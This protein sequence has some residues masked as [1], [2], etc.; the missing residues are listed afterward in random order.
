MHII[1]IRRANLGSAVPFGRFKLESPQSDFMKVRKVG[2][3]I[4]LGL[5]ASL[6][7]KAEPALANVSVTAASGGN[8]IPADRAANAPAPVWTSLGAI[9]IAESSIGKG[10]I[11]S[12]TLILNAPAGF[13]FNP[14]LLPNV[15]FTAGRNIISA[16][17]TVN[18]SNITVTLVVL[19]SDL[20]DTLTIGGSPAIQIR[21]IDGTTLASGNIYRPT[22]GGGT[23]V[24]VGIVSTDSTNGAGGT[25]LGNI[26]EVPGAARQLTAQTLPANSAL[27]GANFSPQPVIQ[28]RDQFGNLR[29]SANG[30]ADNSTV[31]TASLASGTSSLQGTTNVT[32]SNGAATFNNLSY[33]KAE[34]ISVRFSSGSLTGLVTGTI[35]ISPAAASR[36]VFTTQPGSTTYGLPLGTQPVV[37]SQDAYGNS[38]VSGLGVSKPLSLSLSN[39]TGVLQGTTS[40][41]IG[42]GAGNGLATFTNL[43]VTAAGVNLRLTATASGLTNALS[44]PFNVQPVTVTASVTVSN[45][46]YDGTTTAT[47]A[48]RALSGVL[49]VDEVSLNGGVALFANKNAGAGKTVTVTNLSLTGVATN[50][51]QLAATSVST[52]A[53]ISK[54]PLTVT[55]DNKTRVVGQA[56]PPLTASYFGFVN[57]ETLATSGVTGSPALSTAATVG[58]PVGSYAI[59]ATNGSL[60]AVNYSFATLN[61]VLSVIPSGTLFFDDFARTNEPGDLSPWIAQMGTW[62]VTGGVLKSGS[63]VFQSYSYAIITNSW[64]NYSVEGV[65]KFPAGAYGGGFGGQLNPATGAQYLAWVYPE[66]S[67]GGSSILKLIKFNTWTSFGYTNTESIPIQQATLP[68]VGTNWHALRLTFAGNQISVAYDGSEVMSVADL[69]AQPYL[70]GGISVGMWTQSGAD[71][72][73]VDNVFV[74]EAAIIPIANNDSYSVVSGKVLTVSAPGILTNDS[75]LN[76]SA[77]LVTGTTKGSLNLSP[78]GSFAYTPS[79]QFIGTDSFTY[80]ASDSQTNSA[81]ATV[82]INVTTNTPPVAGNDNYVTA[83]DAI[84]TIPPPGVLANDSDANSDALTAVLVNGPAHGSSNL[85]SNGGFV[86]TPTMGFTGPDTFSYRAND[87]SANSGLATVNIFVTEAG[88][89]FSDNFSRPNDPG[90]LSPWIPYTGIWSVTG[91]ALNGGANPAQNYGYAY[92]NGNWNDFSVEGRL[93]FQP[94]AYGGGLGGRLN[95]AT[96]AHYGAWVYPEGSSGGSS[97]L[98]LIKFS[99]WTNFAYNGVSFVPMQ[100]VSLPGVGTNWHNLK[101]TFQT[102]QIKVSYDGNEVMNAT[103]IEAQPIL[104]GGISADMWTDVSPFVMGIDDVVAKNLT[105]PA[106]P[107]GIAVIQKTGS[108]V[109]ITF[110]GTPG[111]TYL[112]QASTNL[113]LPSAW[114]TISTNIAATN[115]Q[116]TL[117]QSTTNYLQRYFRSAKP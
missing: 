103:D 26:R 43:L 115:G 18:S 97:V 11:S 48:T 15:S 35:T 77:A 110:S 62:A 106:G 72:V 27:A 86:Y 111:G 32:A 13:E 44:N 34:A 109:T 96:G 39:G 102:N 47:I 2:R 51:Y 66:G 6:I 22:T 25:S 57:S 79:N 61:G 45:K 23:A 29:N 50:N 10:D 80:R 49:G 59:V 40:L 81:V 74:K 117:V 4:I 95:P 83:F 116:W 99:N 90:P 92:I 36:L 88:V 76:L 8:A 68:G 24:I 9:A 16:V 56:N 30:S 41:D 21:P 20:V 91:G 104:S 85:S 5:L 82:T 87:G 75:G 114:Q 71:Q 55:A 7:I 101:V 65:I 38:S 53:N 112:V 93:Q 89:L 1:P 98:K 28:V 31:V 52:T 105:T 94:G 70:S 63:N 12:G 42:T 64:T 108:A 58:S 14:A 100:Q 19:G 78:N 67:A 54:V 60:N 37:A 113:A 17:G 3:L 73:V 69:E 84:L 33:R 107:P 46:A